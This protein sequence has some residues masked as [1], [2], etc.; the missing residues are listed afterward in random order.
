MKFQSVQSLLAD[1]RKVLERF[2]LVMACAALATLA[3]IILTSEP[4]HLQKE[5]WYLVNL[6]MVATLG[7]PLFLSLKLYGETRDDKK[8]NTRL[9]QG[10]GLIVLVAYYVLLPK[11]LR[12]FD[13]NRYALININAHLLVAVAPFLFLPARNNA[14]WQYNKTLFL[15][16]ILSFIY[17]NT[18]FIGL[19]IAIGVTDYLFEFIKF[20]EKV[21]LHLWYGV[22]GIFNT[23]FFLGGMPKD[24]G[25]LEEEQAYPRGL[26]IFTQFVLIPLVLLYLFIL[27][28]YMAKIV[29]MWSLPKGW[30]SSFIIGASMLG[31]MTLLLVH[32]LTDKK[33]HAWFRV[34][35]RYFYLALFPLIILMAVAIGRRISDYGM[36][37]QRYFVLLFTLW[38]L[39]VALRFTLRPNTN[40]RSIPLTLMILIALAT[41]GPWNAMAVSRQSQMARLKNIL[42]SNGLLKD[43][44]LHKAPQPLKYED[45]KEISNIVSYLERSFGL[46]VL[47]GW[48]ASDISKDWKGLSA[49]DFVIKQLGLEY[50][51]EYRG[52]DESGKQGIYFAFNAVNNQPVKVTGYDYYVPFYL[53]TLQNKPDGIIEK[54]TIPGTEK[55]LEIVYSPSTALL[56]VQWAGQRLPAGE[57]SPA[58][59]KSIREK[60]GF[61]AYN[62]PAEEFT[63]RGKAPGFAFEMRIHTISG[64]VLNEN[65]LPVLSNIQGNILLSVE[66]QSQTTPVAP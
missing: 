13:V 14:F 12:G 28:L 9:L 53:Y 57:F 24:I 6:A 56:S 15:R 60:H 3:S 65:A 61:N 38:L 27:Y 16:F 44:A 59:I 2:P 54:L 23:W 22:V 47:G 35:G 43:K 30:L 32:P 7:I 40:I 50:V 51:G 25:S 66:E 11:H 34:Y 39:V 55:I 36:T 46:Q 19:A 1:A 31:I 49:N 29:V 41:W 10:L 42:V 52:Y 20:D 58:W 21:Y 5:K 33:E 4:H 17:S 64:T 63:Y 18:I 62:L 8:L 37:E 45:I 26:R 48:V